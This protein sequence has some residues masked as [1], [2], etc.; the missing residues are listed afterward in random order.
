MS[1]ESDAAGRHPD[2]TSSVLTYRTAVQDANVA[3]NVHGGWIMKLCDDVAVIAATR[4]ARRRVVTATVDSLRFLSSVQVGDVLTLRATVN[5]SWHTSMEVGVQV[6]AEDVSNGRVIH[7]C[8]A[9]LT[10]VALGE[11]GRPTAVPQLAPITGE[12]KRRCE[13]ANTRRAIRLAAADELRR[14][15]GQ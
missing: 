1:S 6:Q 11:D 12:E 8:T 10:L 13:A 4:L 2:E 14:D 5:A 3:G 15:R 7:V 9:Y